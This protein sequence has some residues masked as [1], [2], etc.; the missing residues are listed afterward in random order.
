MPQKSA[1]SKQPITHFST[2]SDDS[3]ENES[4]KITKTTNIKQ[5]KKVAIMESVSD[6]EAHQVTQSAQ[7]KR[8]RPKKIIQQKPKISQ[9][10]SVHS[11][12]D[13]EDDL[14]LRIPVFEDDN[15]E[16]GG[17]SEK[18]VFTMRDESDNK[19]DKGN[20]QKLKTL[21][22]IDSL[23]GSNDDS[24]DDEEM[25]KD[26]KELLMEL[27][28]KDAII[29]RLKSQMND[30]TAVEAESAPMCSRDAK[31][32]LINMKLININEKNS[33]VISDKTNVACWWCGHNFDTIPCFIP[34]RY[35][36]DKF[37]VFGCFCTYNCAMAYN[38]GMGD[39]KV[40]LRNSLIK[41]LH[42]RIFKMSDQIYPAP[43]KELLQK[44]GGPMTIDE[45]RNNDML[46]KKEHK[47]HIPPLVPLLPSVEEIYR[48][49]AQNP[50][51]V[52]KKMIKK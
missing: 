28:R 8:G 29:K 32:N 46:C 20:K 22:K 2:E 39:Y 40:S 16:Q 49:P 17:S 42:N 41:E 36:N 7:R 31:K 3:S 35:V 33:L 27:K 37:Y 45:F 24:S 23:T 47:I 14:I 38:L 44:F 13:D 6:S 10:Q 52:Y 25:T 19:S 15:D 48:D 4:K 50:K 43:Q 34:D 51:N 9:K 12:Q 18:N 5:E 1:K 30:R 26:V 21:V 11:E